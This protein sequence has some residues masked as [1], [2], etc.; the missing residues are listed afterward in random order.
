MTQE[1]KL[2]VWIWE[3]RVQIPL[4]LTLNRFIQQ[5]YSNTRTNHEI[6]DGLGDKRKH[7]WKMSLWWRHGFKSHLIKSHTQFTLTSLLGT[8][9]STVKY[10]FL[11]MLQQE[12]CGSQVRALPHGFRGCWFDP[13]QLSALRVNG[14][15]CVKAH[16]KKEDTS[17]VSSWSFRHRDQQRLCFYPNWKNKIKLHKNYHFPSLPPPT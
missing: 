11:H 10:K 5:S 15:V 16:P 3:I 14:G 9:G 6:H 12:T 1:I 4:L 13:S 2:C 7:C 8:H 17:T